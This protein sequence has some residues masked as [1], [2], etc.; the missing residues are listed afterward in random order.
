MRG[1]KSYVSAP[2]AFSNDAKRL[3]V[4]TGATVSIFSTSTGLQTSSLEGH[5]ALVTS[6]IVVPA[7]S[8]ASK[9][10]CFCWTSSLDGTIRYWDF[11][12]PELMKTIDVKMPIYSMV[13]PSILGQPANDD[14][15]PSQ[16]FAYM[17]VEE[18]KVQENKPKALRGQIR[19][20]NLTDSRLA[21]GLILG[22]TQRPVP[23]IISASGKFFGTQSKRK[24]LIWKVPAKDSVSSVAKK[25]TL[26]H[27]KNL[28][29]LAFHPTNRIVAAGDVTGRILIWRGFGNQTF[30]IGDKLANGRLIQHE[31]ERPGVRGDDDA[32]SCTT[33]HWH[34]SEVNVLSFSSDGAYLYSGGREGVLVVWQLDTG[35]K[36]FLPRI[37]SPLLYFTDSP[38]PTLSSISCADNRIHILKMPSMEILKS[39]SGIKLPCSFPE[40]KESPCSKFAFDYSAGLVALR[41]EN[42]CIQLYSLFDDREISEIQVCER[43]HQ[44]GDDV[45]VIVTLVALSQDGSMMCT[46]EVRL[47]EEDIGALVCLK[48]WASAS[49]NKSFCLST[50]IYEPHRDAGVSAVAFHPT[51][52]MAV[53]SS[54]GGDF[55]I[56]VCKDDIQQKSEMLQNS[57]WMCHA[58]GSYKKRPMTA[59]AFSADGSVLAVAAETVIT[60]WD[61][62]KNVLVAIIGEMQE[63]IMNLSFVGKSEYLVSVSRGSKPRLAVWSMSK[64]SVSW[65]YKLHVEDVACAVD[66]SLFAVLVLPKSS[67]VDSNESI[68]QGKNGVILLF[69]ATDPV[70]V[71]TWSAREASGGGVAFIQGNQS[72][73]QQNVSPEFLV[74]MNGDHE[75]VVFDPNDSDA[76]ELSLTRPGHVVPEETGQ[77]GYASIYGELPEFE[78]KKNQSLL[79]PSGP[80][81]RPWETLFSGS[82]HNL[83]PL[84][85]LCSAFLESLLEKRTAIVE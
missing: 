6:I 51:R 57:G 38:D 56:W 73:F 15:K 49:Q 85:K 35:K 34:P 53:S 28:T 80:S 21:G 84:T 26:H 81:E 29:V 31:E 63:S 30:P 1:G 42:Y 20:C 2:P 58:V 74:Y 47:P 77:F 17:S 3:L 67:T 39:I 60:L 70:P 5:K 61:P 68:F 41:M 9:V 69:N 25:I 65:S 71:A 43:N 27:T 22:E 52:N 10:L 18:T 62:E 14:E 12:A 72:S 16:V 23:I 75:Y 50:I 83:P 8:P 40:V 76:P 79:G 55:K 54:Y 32:D 37:G 59:V 33:W 48:F 24:L 4:C 36:K 64:L 46:T 45:T 66:S 82:S 11:S 44:P 19:K 7:S 78:L 13:I